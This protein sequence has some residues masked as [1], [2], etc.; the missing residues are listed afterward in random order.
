MNI[1][2]YHVPVPQIDQRV[3]STVLANWQRTWRKHGWEPVIL[4]HQHARSNPGYNQYR[5]AMSKKPMMN[6]KEYELACFMRWLAMETVGGGVHCDYD[7]MNNGLSPMDVKP[8]LD[9]GKMTLYEPAHVPS[10]VSGSRE[11]YRRMCDHFARFELS[12]YK[13]HMMAESQGGKKVSD[14]FILANDPSVVRPHKLVWEFH[15]EPGWQ[16]AKVIHFSHWA[17]EG[18]GKVHAIPAWLKTR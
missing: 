10:M 2:T 13:P 6:S 1:Y 11:E 7:V 3:E 12:H 16:G 17:C 9:D 4:S 14:M 18:I 15:R 5:E 8:F